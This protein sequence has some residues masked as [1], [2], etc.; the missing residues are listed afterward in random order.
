MFIYSKRN[1]IIPAPDNSRNIFIK[2]GFVG[3]VPDWVGDT[4]YFKALVEDGKIT[5]PPSHK[6]KDT[7]KADEA[8]V[9][10]RRGKK[11]SEEV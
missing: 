3:D 2:A 7:Q 11:V 10:V 4:P 5:I 9:K 1:V 6:D 8:P